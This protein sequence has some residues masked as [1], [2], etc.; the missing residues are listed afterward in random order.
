MHTLR[1]FTIGQLI[2]LHRGKVRELYELDEE[3]LLLIAT[4][5]LSAFDN[6]LETPI[7][8][9][10]EVLNSLAAWWFQQLE[11]I[12]PNHLVSTPDPAV[13]VVRKLEPVLIETV[14]RGYM[15][16]SMWRA[17]Q[18]GQRTFWG[19]T[20][21][22]GLTV[23]ARLPF[24]LV[25]PTTKE[26]VDRPIEAEAI[27][28]EGWT[29]EEIWVAMR[30]TALK[31]FEKGTEI[32]AER[33]IVLVDTKYEFGLLDGELVLMDEVHTPDSSRFWD[34]ADYAADPVNAQQ[35]DK[36]FVRKWLMTHKVG[37]AYPKALPPEIVDETS[38]RYLEIFERITGH[39]LH[40]DPRMPALRLYENLSQSE[41]IAEGF[42]TII[43][44]SPADLEHAEKIRK[45]VTDY[46]I[47]CHLRVGSAHKNGE[48]VGEM[49]AYYN[50]AIEPGAVIAVAGLSNG[51]G[52]ALAANL[53]LPC[54]SCPPFKDRGDYLANI[55]SSIMMPSKT[56]AG[57]AIR[58][59]EAARLA[60][61]ALNLPS[62]KRA[63]AQEII[64]TKAGIRAA[65]AELR[66]R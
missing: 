5:R 65:D 55:H 43:M 59:S 56:P 61:R 21:P 7:R 4:D 27:V 32:L 23:N 48:N 1:D 14:V 45:T 28:S 40:L 18:K 2:H 66:R 62:L 33:G 16:G 49:A 41:I 36:E 9:K 19:Q 24:P 13:S 53:V 39:A 29:T 42:V 17:Y 35:M 58:P 34:A 10:G 6:V 11:D 38:H 20:L 31:L 54:I 50:Q 3:H 26:K 63:F 64:E 60:L 12:V 46:G 30:D 25:T 47:P 51:L 22:D 57:T 52:G 37:G 44:G 15:A 8:H